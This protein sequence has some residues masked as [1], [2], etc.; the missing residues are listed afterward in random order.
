M[1]RTVSGTQKR[2]QRT[3]Q[4]VDAH[5]VRVVELVR[6]EVSTTQLHKELEQVHEILE[7]QAVEAERDSGSE[8]QGRDCQHQAEPPQVA[9][10]MHGISDR[11][12]TALNCSCKRAM[13][14]AHGR[15]SAPAVSRGQRKVR[16][17]KRYNVLRCTEL[18]L[19]VQQAQLLHHLIRQQQRHILCMFTVHAYAIR[20]R[21]RCLP[22]A[23]RSPSQHPQSP[24][25]K[26][27]KSLVRCKQRHG[28]L[29]PPALPSFGPQPP[30][31]T[32]AHNLR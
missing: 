16:A 11:A 29:T 28:S 27:F 23:N 10:P 26:P 15:W 12:A 1:V 4:R 7:L 2:S 8:R 14:R 3:Q 6:R 25:K 22:S 32:S 13:R 31:E 24:R 17:W 30:R 21:A 20:C 19:E 5:G 18:G 9:H